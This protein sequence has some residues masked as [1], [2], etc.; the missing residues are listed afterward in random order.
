[1]HVHEQVQISAY[2]VQISANQV[3]K[4]CINPPP[5]RGRA[6]PRRFRGRKRRVPRTKK[7]G[8][9]SRFRPGE[10]G[11]RKAPGPGSP[12]GE[13]GSWTRR[14]P[15]FLSRGGFLLGGEREALRTGQGPHP[16][17]KM[18]RVQ[19]GH[20]CGKGEV[21][22]GGGGEGGDQ[23]CTRPPLACRFMPRPIPSP[24]QVCH[25]RAPRIPRPVLFPRPSR[26]PES[27]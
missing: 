17:P 1:M 15:R 18:L 7:A 5:P 14:R 19:P 16:G 22:R 6:L 25:A 20:Y 27:P 10:A 26:P 3:H 13:A 12:S 9:A 2:R 23:R 24:G 21:A 8:S 4:R 11:S